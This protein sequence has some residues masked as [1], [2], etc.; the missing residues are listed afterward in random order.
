MKFP[1][2]QE[3]LMST[4]LGEAKNNRGHDRLFSENQLENELELLG[5]SLS[6]LFRYSTC[7]FGCPGEGRTHVLEPYAG[8]TYNLSLVSFVLLRSGLYDES[9]TVLR[10]IG[11]IANLVFLFISDY[12]KSIEMWFHLSEKERRNEFFPGRVRKKIEEL[13]LTEL[14]PMRREAYSFLCE[15]SVHIEVIWAFYFVA[16]IRDFLP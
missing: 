13:N 2:G 16:K 9:M 4:I 8:R 1:T 6:Y 11:E 3:Y 15:Q 14:M 5:T 12:P 10:S 7:Y